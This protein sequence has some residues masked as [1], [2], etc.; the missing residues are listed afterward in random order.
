[1]IFI[2]LIKNPYSLAKYIQ[3]NKYTINIKLLRS[4]LSY[5]IRE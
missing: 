1:M 2:M 3:A 4:Y 5:V